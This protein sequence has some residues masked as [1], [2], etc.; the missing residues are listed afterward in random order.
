MTWYKFFEQAL[1][2]ECNVLKCLNNILFLFYIYISSFYSTYS[3]DCVNRVCFCL[4][5]RASGAG[6]KPLP[7][8][9]DADGAGDEEEVA[10]GEEVPQQTQHCGG[11]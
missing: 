3:H 5:Q 4:C 9:D 1:T 2:K 11:S 8:G 7:P 6:S 10:I